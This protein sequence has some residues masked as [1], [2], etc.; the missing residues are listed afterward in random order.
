MKA[1]L[2]I[3]VRARRN[4]GTLIGRFV[5]LAVLATLGLAP[6]LVHGADPKGSGP[7]GKSSAVTLESIPGSTAKRVTLT[8]KAAERLGIETGKVAY[9]SVTR[10]QMVGGMI[11][12]PATKPPEQTAGGGIFGGAGGYAR[13]QVAA[14]PPTAAPAP[15]AARG[16]WVSV[17][18]SEAEWDRLAQNTSARILPLATP[19]N[20][21]KA[22][23]AKPVGWPPLE[24][25][26][27]SMLTLYYVVPG[28]DHG[29]E[30]GQRV[31]VEL[32]MTGGDGKR[33]QGWQK[34]V[35]YSAVYYDA[36]GDAWVYVNTKPLVFE[37][38]RISVERIVGDLAVVSKGPDVGTPIVTVGAPLLYGAEVF[39]K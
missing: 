28:K 1:K 23:T 14:A 25:A 19:G 4:A 31:R 11:T 30:L 13:V 38:Q 27:R 7:V 10:K 36:K 39:G 6:G 24:D 17:A 29:L 15:P 32:Q 3:A 22:L 12:P 18:L 37:R 8:A 20:P 2:M 33:D 5:A 35:P 26:K 16:A 21:G 34:V 9:S